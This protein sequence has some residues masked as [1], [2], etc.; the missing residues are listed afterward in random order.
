MPFDPKL[1]MVC[2]SAGFE[3]HAMADYALAAIHAINRDLSHLFA[4][5]ARR[6]CAGRLLRPAEGQQA[7]V[8]GAGPVGAGGS[9]GRSHP[10][11]RANPR[12]GLC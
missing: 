4:R 2:N 6:E 5:Q 11:C 12:S 1:L 7:V 10:A 9:S 3:A 8:L